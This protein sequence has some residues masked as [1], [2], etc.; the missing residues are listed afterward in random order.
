ME[1]LTRISETRFPTCPRISQIPL[2]I[3]SA[4]SPSELNAASPL[5]L[6]SGMCLL[7]PAD[8]GFGD[9]LASALPFE[10]D[11]DPML[12]LLPPRRCC[13][14]GGEG[15]SIG[16]SRTVLFWR[17]IVDPVEGDGF[18]RSISAC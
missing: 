18:A 11:P 3:T 5:K 2:A 9:I 12:L 1:T 8:R 13:G 6:P 17:T 14:G 4:R 16:I 10:S 7:N 15:A